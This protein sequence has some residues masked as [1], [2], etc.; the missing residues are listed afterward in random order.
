MTCFCDVYIWHF[1]HGYTKVTNPSP[2][3]PGFHSSPK[4]TCKESLLVCVPSSLARSEEQ[5][6]IYL[7]SS[8]SAVY[9]KPG[10]FSESQF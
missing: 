4:T 7:K 6:Q 9:A 1:G 8:L 3:A 5:S 2:S 10:I